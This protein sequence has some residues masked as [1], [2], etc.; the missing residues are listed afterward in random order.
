[1]IGKNLAQ[2]STVD[3][4]TAFAVFLDGRDESGMVSH[5][6][7]RNA[8]PVVIANALT[9]RDTALK[10]AAEAYMNDLGAKGNL[11]LEAEVKAVL[12]GAVTIAD[13]DD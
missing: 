11:Q 6:L 8:V 10:S 3:P 4:A 2:A 12:D 7:T 1:M 5:D 9:V 13:I